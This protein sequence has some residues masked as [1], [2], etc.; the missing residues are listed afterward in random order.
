MLLWFL[1][2]GIATVWFVFR[3]PRF[4]YRVLALGLLLPDAVDGLTG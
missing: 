2:T 4:D 3:D 1:G